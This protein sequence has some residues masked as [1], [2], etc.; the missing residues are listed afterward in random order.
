MVDIRLIREL[1]QL[2]SEND[3]TAIELR[4]GADHLCLKAR[5]DEAP[6][7]VASCPPPPT[8]LPLVESPAEELALAEPTK[9]ADDADA[10]LVPISSPMVGTF[11]SAPSPDDAPFVTVGSV[12]TPTTDVCIVETMKTFNKIEAEVAGT[13]ER[14]LVANET[15][16]QKDQPLFLVRPHG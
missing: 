8:A 4:D 13:I 3:I 5:A 6:A 10:G 2:M 14:I 11:Y 1:A 15:D 9:P 16:V 7:V 12:V